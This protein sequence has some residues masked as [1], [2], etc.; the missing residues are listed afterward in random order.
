MEPPLNCFEALGQAAVPSQPEG[1]VAWQSLP[2]PTDSERRGSQA[3]EI[4]MAPLVLLLYFLK[5]LS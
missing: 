2:A 4:T 1:W 3:A 5:S